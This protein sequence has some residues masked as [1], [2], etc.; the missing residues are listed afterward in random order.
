M[1]IGPAPMIMMVFMSVR[2]GISEGQFDLRQRL[3][4]QKRI[5]L[6]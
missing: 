5:V 3:Q 1:T 2:L 6:R 4:A